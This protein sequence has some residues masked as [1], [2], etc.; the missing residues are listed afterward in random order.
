M[1]YVVSF[2][3][4]FTVLN[5]RCFVNGA[6]KSDQQ[7]LAGTTIM[8]RK[9]EGGDSVSILPAEVIDTRHGTRNDYAWGQVK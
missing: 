2:R 4:P 8:V 6:C 9:A 5:T 3:V 1:N 7:L